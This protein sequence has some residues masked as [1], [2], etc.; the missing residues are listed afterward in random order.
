MLKTTTKLRIARLA[1]R[2]LVA[3]RATFGLG[4]ETTVTRRGLRWYLNLREGIDLA[5]YLGVYETDTLNALVKR[6]RE[7]NVVIDIGAN[8]GALSLP[9]ALLVGAAGQVHAF[10]AADAALHAS[11]PLTESVGLHAA[12]C[13]TSMPQAAA[14]RAWV[15][16]GCGLNII[17]DA[18]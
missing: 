2:L 3:A 15:P 16:Y 1:S 13:G 8:I 17:G 4:A 9:L 11:G 18:S 10:A 12:H 7:G 6:V 5:I 14:L